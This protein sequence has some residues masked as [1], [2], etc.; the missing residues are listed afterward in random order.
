MQV[1][2]ECTLIHLGDYFLNLTVQTCSINR[3]YFHRSLGKPRHCYVQDDAVRVYFAFGDHDWV[4]LMQHQ[5]AVD[6][7]KR[8][9]S[10]DS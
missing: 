10:F 2:A 3:R 5:P 9:L 6:C 4:T 8:V 1:L 7:L